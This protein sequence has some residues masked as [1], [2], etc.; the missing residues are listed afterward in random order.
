MNTTFIILKL[1]VFVRI[2]KINLDMK[3]NKSL[4]EFYQ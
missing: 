4:V 1:Y 2:H 3:Q